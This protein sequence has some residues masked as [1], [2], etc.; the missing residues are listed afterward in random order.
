[1]ASQSSM[2]FNMSS[3]MKLLH[4]LNLAAFLTGFDDI[5]ADIDHVVKF[6]PCNNAGYQNEHF[7]VTENTF[8]SSH[9]RAQNSQI[10]CHEIC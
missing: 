5:F 3:Y 10:Q 6:N 8:N 7:V 4:G 9:E 1:M 2:S